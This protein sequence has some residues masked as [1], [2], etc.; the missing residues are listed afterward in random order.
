MASKLYLVKSLVRRAL[1]N[2][3]FSWRTDLEGA[4]AALN[5]FHAGLEG[6]LSAEPEGRATTVTSSMG[7]KSFSWSVPAELSPADV[8]EV[9]ERALAWLERC[10]TV[11]QARLLLVRRKNSRPDFSRFCL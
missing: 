10:E 7:G 4:R 3:D 5:E 1:Q 9:A 8:L 2:E 6:V 11:D